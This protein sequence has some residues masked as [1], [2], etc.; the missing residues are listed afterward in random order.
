MTV[1]LNPEGSEDAI[2]SIGEKNP[3]KRIAVTG[4]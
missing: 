4:L 3:Q 2:V 1:Y